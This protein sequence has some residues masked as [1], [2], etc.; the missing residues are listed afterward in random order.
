MWP[1]CRLW[2]LP[3]LRGAVKSLQACRHFQDV[4]F[5]LSWVCAACS[6]SMHG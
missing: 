2:L 4:L 6:A 3:F 1:C 5:V